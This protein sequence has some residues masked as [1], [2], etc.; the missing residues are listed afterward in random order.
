[1]NSISSSVLNQCNY[2]LVKILANYEW[3]PCGYGT[4]RVEHKS[5]YMGLLKDLGLLNIFE[6]SIAGANQTA[7][8]NQRER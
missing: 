5:A 1:M 4:K 7:N 2:D 6:L 8:M 3:M